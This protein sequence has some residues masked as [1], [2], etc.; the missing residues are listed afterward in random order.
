MDAALEALKTRMPEARLLSVQ[1][2]QG[3][4]QQSLEVVLPAYGANRPRPCIMM[5]GPTAWT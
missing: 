4:A 1:L 2:G 5:P 3:P